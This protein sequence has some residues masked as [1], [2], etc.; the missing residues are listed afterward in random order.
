MLWTALSPEQQSEWVKVSDLGFVHRKLASQYLVTVEKK[1]ALYDAVQ[2]IVDNPDDHFPNTG[3]CKRFSLSTYIKRK[4]KGKI[5]GLII[6]E[7]HNYNN[8]AP[9]VRKCVV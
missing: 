8:S 3:A 4:M 9:G 5:D 1:P 6:D 7:L 2:S